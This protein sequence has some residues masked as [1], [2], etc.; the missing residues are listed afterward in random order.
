[1]VPGAA[2]DVSAVLVEGPW[3]HRLVAA[4]GAR[5]HVAELG[6]GP[7]FLLLLD[8]PQFWWAW[9]S[10]LVALAS[11]GYTAVAIDLFGYSVSDYPPRGY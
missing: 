2:A 8:F 3:R 10:Q 5:F 4:H 7:L 11:A 6:S 9:R 1:M